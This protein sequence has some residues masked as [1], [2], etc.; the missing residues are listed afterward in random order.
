M[1]EALD[2][3]KVV[4]HLIERV[5]N[6]RIERNKNGSEHIDPLAADA[7]D[8]WTKQVRVISCA[9]IPALR[10][11]AQTQ[12]GDEYTAAC[13]ELMKVEP[14]SLNRFGVPDA[15]S[16]HEML[17]EIVV[18]I[19]DALDGPE[20][21][22]ALRRIWESV[23]NTDTPIPKGLDRFL[24]VEV[25]DAQCVK[26]GLPPPAR[27]PPHKKRMCEWMVKPEKWG[28]PV[29]YG[30]G[31]RRLEPLLKREAALVRRAIAVQLP[32]DRVLVA[33]NPVCPQCD[34]V[35]TDTELAEGRVACP[36]CLAANKIQW[37]AGPKL[38]WIVFVMQSRCEAE[39]AKNKGEIKHF[40]DIE[41]KF[42]DTMLKVK[43][44]LRRLGRLELREE[45]TADFIDRT[46]PEVVCELLMERGESSS[47]KAVR[48]MLLHDVLAVL[49]GTQPNESEGP[50]SADDAGRQTPPVTSA[51]G[52][53]AKSLDTAA[54]D[55]SAKELPDKQTPTQ[56]LPSQEFWDNAT[57]QPRKLFA[58]LRDNDWRAS[59]AKFEDAIWGEPQTNDTLRKSL[60]R[61]NDELRKWVNGW[62]VDW[63]SPLDAPDAEIWVN[64]PGQE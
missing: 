40:K 15:T 21:G 53:V 58:F 31:L 14:L 36:E 64:R 13:H 45:V 5:W 33:P 20:P 51:V 27:I 30:A 54:I 25:V 44:Q 34:R 28:D 16:H 18:R 38:S 55:A 35:R 46:L 2:V 47:I 29:R 6:A 49:E 62:E 11:F 26:R 12:F 39:A 50:E 17:R 3:T 19:L 32:E 37:E 24:P 1:V 22:E 42:A 23:S 56:P 59:R 9:S 61:L 60:R 52:V 57:A 43:R 10:A 41:A 7:S 4:A 8:E 48:E 63:Q